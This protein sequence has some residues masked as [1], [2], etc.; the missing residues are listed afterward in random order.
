MGGS[1]VSMNDLDAW[2]PSRPHSFV[3]HIAHSMKSDREE[4]RFTRSTKR[5]D[6]LERK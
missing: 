4:Y 5:Q 3:G 2:G 1:S 6:F